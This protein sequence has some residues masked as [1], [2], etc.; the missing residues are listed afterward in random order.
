MLHRRHVA[1]GGCSS[2][3]VPGWHV[4]LELLLAN[5]THASLAAKQ[6]AKIAAPRNSKLIITRIPE[7]GTAAPPR[8]SPFTAG[9]SEVACP[10]K[11]PA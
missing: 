4:E 2:S 6:R 3:V 5:I 9:R 8:R 7:F 1:D 10:V 11:F